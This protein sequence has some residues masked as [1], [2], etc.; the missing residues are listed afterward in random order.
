MPEPTMLTLCDALQGEDVEQNLMDQVGDH[1]Y[2]CDLFNIIQINPVEWCDNKPQGELTI[3]QMFEQ[4]AERWQ[5]DLVENIRSEAKYHKETRYIIIDGDT[6]WDG[7]HRMVAF[8]LEGIT[9]VDAL[10]MSKSV[11]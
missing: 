7:F 9:S 1:S 4:N 11:N 8:A 3:R 10:D 2:H 6:L 5:R